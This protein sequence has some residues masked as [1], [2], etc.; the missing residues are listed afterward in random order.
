MSI[1]IISVLGTNLYEPVYY[2]GKRKDPIETDFIQAA[3]INEY[4]EQIKDD[5]KVTV[6]VTEK[7]K[8]DNWKDR[9]Y[10]AFE[11]SKAE[12]W[13]S[14]KK[15]KVIEGETKQGLASAINELFPEIA[16]RVECVQIPNMKNEAEIWDVFGKIYDCINEK[17]EL[18]FD[19]THS[20]RSIPM[21]AVTVINYAKALKQC[22]LEAVYYGAFEAAEKNDE[23]N[24]KIA[25]IIDLTVFNEILEWTYAADSF[26]R[27]GNV[28]KMEEAYKL[29]YNRIPDDEKRYWKPIDTII[30]DMKSM[31]LGILTCRGV[32][33][34]ALANKKN[35]EKKSVKQAYLKLAD[36][37]KKEEKGV[38][39]S[40]TGNKTELGREIIP[41][42]ELL[43]AATNKFNSFSNCKKDYEV[44]IEMIRWSI[45]YHMIQQ[46]YTALE[47]TIKTYVCELYGIDDISLD[48]RE[49]IVSKMLNAYPRKTPECREEA[50]RYITQKDSRFPAVY[51]ELDSDMR[52]KVDCMLM[53][54]PEELFQLAQGVKKYRN[55]INHMGFNHET[56]T[57]D[58][59]EK[60]LGE[61]FDKFVDIVDKMKDVE[62]MKQ[63]APVAHRGFTHAGV[64][65]ADDVFAT[66]LL[67]IKYPDIVIERGTEVPENYDGIVYDIGR[68]KYDH[69][70]AEHRVRENGVPYAAFGLLWEEY[71]PE[72]VGEEM[73][74]AFDEEFIQHIDL[75]DNT[76]KAEAVCSMIAGYN[77]FWNE[78]SN[79]DEQF[80]KAVKVAKEM[81]ER[82]IDNLKSKKSALEKVSEQISQAKNQVL[83]LEKA[84]PWKEALV[85]TDILYVIMESARG[86]YNVQA[87]PK[88]VNTTDLKKAF[89]KEWWGASR[90][91]LVKM[92]GIATLSFCHSTGFLCAT[93]TL[94]DAMKLA[95][96]AVKA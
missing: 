14:S 35:K 18:I 84:M 71:G 62:V 77:S 73:A 81:L 65:H 55:D 63:N 94:E 24:K 72:L 92:T 5:G 58:S 87:V 86:G 29:R 74:K 75:S 21:L 10:T 79:Q 41:M 83:V 47:E 91:E 12:K 28:D 13:V 49:D 60:K 56:R 33:S 80:N 40:Q 42:I 68:G 4:R 15:D 20:F 45:Q 34:A 61:Y 8:N 31:G 27:Y 22:H 30:N 57:S 78:E 52:K 48:N 59:L 17:D 85:D 95:E 70:Q 67:K 38:S 37:I 43:K 26:I 19:I 89:P 76:G 16:D 66:A 88:A 44:G 96:Y 7:S 54:L 1:H 23:G 2:Q 39:I 32:D 82:L 6:F 46:G 36:S 69:H 11:V 3:V 25:P 50:F 9:E 51:N 90:E 64:F 53:E 93:E